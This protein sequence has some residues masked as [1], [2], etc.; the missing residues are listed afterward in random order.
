MNGYQF[1]SDGLDTQICYI[2]ML[3]IYVMYMYIYAIQID[4]NQ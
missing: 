4:N 1:D 3:Y 2:Y